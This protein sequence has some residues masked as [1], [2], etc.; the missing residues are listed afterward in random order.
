VSRLRQS[1]CDVGVFGK[2]SVAPDPASIAVDRSNSIKASRVPVSAILTYV[3]EVAKESTLCRR[4]LKNWPLLA[5]DELLCGAMVCGHAVL[6]KEA[7][8]SVQMSSDG[9]CEW[10]VALIA[11]EA[12]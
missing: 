2:R 10:P 9:S 8:S 7:A 4:R 3:I 1:P 6:L 11:K 12:T 5:G